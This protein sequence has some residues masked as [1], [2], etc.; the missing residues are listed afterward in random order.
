M[1][2]RQREHKKQP[3]QKTTNNK[4]KKKKKKT[5]PT[6]K[7]KTKANHKSTVEGEIEAKRVTSS[8]SMRTTNKG[9]E[10]QK[11]PNTKVFA[12]T[13]VHQLVPSYVQKGGRTKTLRIHE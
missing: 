3:K 1:G 13:K 9:G 11:E 5:T 8:S 12:Y 4:K 2:K 7:K 6:K 10:T